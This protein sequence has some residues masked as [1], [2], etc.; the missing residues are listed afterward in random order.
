M[1]PQR[2]AATSWNW[3]RTRNCGSSSPRAIISRF[4]KEDTFQSRSN[5]SGTD[6][7]LADQAPDFDARIHLPPR[8]S[9]AGRN[10][11]RSCCVTPCP[12]GVKTDARPKPAYPGSATAHTDPSLRQYPASGW[13]EHLARG[14]YARALLAAGAA[15]VI[16]VDR[17]PL[18]LNMARDWGAEFGAA[19]APCAGQFRGS[20]MRM[21]ASRW[22][23][24]CWILG[25]SSMQLDLPERGFSFFQGWSAG[26]AHVAIRSVSAP[27]SSTARRKR[28]WPISCSIMARNAPAGRIAR[29]SC[30]RGQRPR[31]SAPG[32]LAQIVSGCLR[33]P[34][35]GQSHPGHAQFPRLAHCRECPNSTRLWTG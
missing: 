11:G 20:W 19:L 21:R 33:R 30:A 14:G 4:W 26:H 34:K 10:R 17:D 35:P 27:I 7:F 31:S 24:W 1:L 15:Q 8:P 23:V 18:A 2:P 5:P 9:S 13:M 12:A 3:N 29:R 32:Q 16:G 28:H 25:S 22:T 6:V